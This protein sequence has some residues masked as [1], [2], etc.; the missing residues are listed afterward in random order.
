M[1]EQTLRLILGQMDTAIADGDIEFTQFLN[2]EDGSGYPVWKIQT[3]E[4]EWVLKAAK[5][6]EMEIYGSFLRNAG[7]W[8]PRLHGSCVREDQ[9][10]LLMEYVQGEDLIRCDRRKLTLALDALIACQEQFWEK[11]ELS[12]RGTTFE[13]SFQRRVRRGQYLNAPELEAAYEIFLGLYAEVPRTLC[14]DDLLPFN[15]L[16]GRERAV[17]IDWETAG[18]MPYPVPLVR[19]I[20]HGSEDEADFFYLTG[21]DREFAIG[22]YYKNL[23]QSK[24]ISYEDYR[25]ALDYFLLFEYCEWIMLGNRYPDADMVRYHKY[26]K[27][28]KELVKRL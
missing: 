28:A 18:I 11:R 16:A 20:A 3:G 25:R 12:D 24:G 27:M 5:D 21:E 13:E 14:H 2:Q 17:M 7:A 23:I 6:H 26:M 19:L 15:V 1:D 8:A 22:Y 10:F 9:A 4:R